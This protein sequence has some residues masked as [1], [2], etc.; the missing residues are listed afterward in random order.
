M[1]QPE[2]CAESLNGESDN[3]VH[4]GSRSAESRLKATAQNSVNTVRLQ[5]A[6][7]KALKLREAGNQAY[8]AGDYQL[9]TQIYG[10]A[11]Y[12]IVQLKGLRHLGAIPSDDWNFVQTITEMQFKVYSNEAASWLKYESYA[13]EDGEVSRF[14]KALTRTERALEALE[15][16]PTAWK[17]SDGEMAKLLYRR[18]LACDGLEDYGGALEEVEKARQLAPAD[19][20]IRKLQDRIKGFRRFD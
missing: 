4:T 6:L 15:N 14:Q 16:H 5:N 20:T 17:P 11:S 9:S 8:R 13:P 2:A 12:D 7:N 18:A 1:D 19:A 3:I 10:D